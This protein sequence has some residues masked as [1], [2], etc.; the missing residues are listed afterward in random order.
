MKQF[1]N[2]PEADSNKRLKQSA[3]DFKV[4]FKIEKVNRNDKVE[5]E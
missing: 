5:N 1:F 3:T 2:P 4:I